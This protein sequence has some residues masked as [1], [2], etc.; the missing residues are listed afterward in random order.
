MLLRDKITEGGFTLDWRRVEETVNLV[1]KQQR[2]KIERLGTSRIN[3]KAPA[4][5]LSP[6]SSSTFSKGKTL[7]ERTLKELMRGRE[8]KVK[9]GV[10]TENTISY[11]SRPTERPKDF[12]MRCIWCDDANYKQS[13]CGLYVDA[14]KSDIITFKEGRISDATTYEPLNTNFGRREMRKLMDDIIGRNNLSHSKDVESYIIGVEHKMEISTHVSR[15]PMVK[16]AQ[17]IRRLT[18]WDDLVDAITIKPYLMS[19]HE[20]K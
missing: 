11:F 20:E 3:V 12:V 1:A 16:R 14:M 9:M 4:T 18:R 8:L 13:D 10:L 15:E 5:T 6:S 2:V 7:D 19:E 17:T